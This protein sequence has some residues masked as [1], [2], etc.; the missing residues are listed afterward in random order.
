MEY[1]GTV[2]F[3]GRMFEGY[4]DIIKIDPAKGDTLQQAVTNA[5]LLR[6]DALQVSIRTREFPGHPWICTWK[7]YWLHEP[8]TF[9]WFKHPALPDR[10]FDPDPLADPCTCE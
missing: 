10:S 1:D 7:R 3:R 4:V 6:S 2:A 9:Q 8:F 5:A